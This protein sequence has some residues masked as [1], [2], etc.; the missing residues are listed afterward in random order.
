MGNLYWRR[1]ESTPPNGR[2]R[3][4]QLEV[5]GEGWSM[6]PLTPEMK[7]EVIRKQGDLRFPIEWTS[8]GE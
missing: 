3:H 7:A 4:Q 6:G 1:R 8:L 2:T 5:F